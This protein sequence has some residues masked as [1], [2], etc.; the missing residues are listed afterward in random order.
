MKA[1]YLFHPPYDTGHKT[2]IKH[3][4]ARIFFRCRWLP[5]YSDA[6]TTVAR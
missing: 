6:K 4:N 1:P 2:S 3:Q 5:R